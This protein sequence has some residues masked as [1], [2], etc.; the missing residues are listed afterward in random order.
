MN[1]D[2]QTSVHNQNRQQGFGVCQ[3]IEIYSTC[4]QKI[5]ICLSS[6]H[7]PLTWPLFKRQIVYVFADE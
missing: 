1:V 5:Q 2:L 6:F 7:L 3:I 4:R